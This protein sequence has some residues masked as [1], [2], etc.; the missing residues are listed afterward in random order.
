MNY[1]EMMLAA[2]RGE[3]VDKIPWAPR[4]DLWYIANKA[5]GT[6]PEKFTG[7][8]TVG[9][10]KEFNMACH[11]V[12]A[13]YTMARDAEE[14]FLLTGFVLDTHPDYPYRLKVSGLSTE[15]RHDGENYYTTIKTKAGDVTTHAVLTEEM[16]KNGISYPFVKS[17]PIKS[18]DDFEAVAQVFEHL[19]VIPTPNE[20]KKFQK[21]IG[22]SGLAVA[23]GVI[24]ASPM[25]IILH[26]LMPMLDFFMAWGEHRDSLKMLAQRI[27]PFFDTVLNAVVQCDAETVFWGA[28]YDQ[29]TTWPPFFKDEIAPWLAKVSKRLHEEGK[30]LLT[31]TDGENKSLLPLYPTCGIDVAESVCPSPMTKSSL[32]EIRKGMG[33]RTAVWG[34]IPSIVLLDAHMKG[35]EFE[36]YLN[37]LFREIGAGEKLIL[38]VSDNIPPEVNLSRLENIRN[39]IDQFGPVKTDII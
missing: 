35:D 8:D 12:G 4:M 7:L 24:S 25:H 16:K 27:E 38:G 22:D 2:I 9:I 23:A 33:S 29:N 19:E 18:L 37:T 13:D 6:L 15:F 34:G 32:R 26:G 36:Q 5:R 30:L 17:H 31:H 39:R 10:A 20:Y 21:R 14:H 11:A 3:S 28:N 1:R